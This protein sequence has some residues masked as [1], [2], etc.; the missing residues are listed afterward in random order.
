MDCID[1]YAYTSKLRKINPQLKAA[2]AA[3][4]L[5]FC[6]GVN[7]ILISVVIFLAMGAVTTL[8]GGL[9]LRRYVVFL[10]IPLA[11]LVLGTFAI[12]IDISAHP[13]GQILFPI[14]KS[15]VYLPQG[16]A[17]LALGLILKAMAAVS[18]MYMLVLSTPAGEV[19]GVLRRLHVP[20]IFVELM[21]LVYRFIFVILNTQRT[22]KQAAAS[23]MGYCDF[24]TSCQSFGRIAGNLFLVSL[25]KSN[26][27]YDALE[28]RCYEGELLFL[29]EEKPV[30]SK[31]V[32]AVVCYFTLLLVVFF[33]SS[34]A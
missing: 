15:F 7:S 5:L 26:T 1:Y 33:I 3:A 9:P 4:S 31:Q 25:K 21:N 10:R 22:M 29:E 28:A 24:K 16:G 12:A 32:G 20:K 30:K 2:V 17:Q 11:F 34:K 6:I 27:Y 23:R 19:I 14:L 18:A 13:Q 8:A